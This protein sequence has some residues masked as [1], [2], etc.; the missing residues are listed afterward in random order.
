MHVDSGYKGTRIRE[1]FTEPFIV[2]EQR[3]ARNKKHDTPES[4]DEV[5]R[6]EGIG[7]EGRFH[8][9]LKDAGIY[10][11]EEFLQAY[12]R[13]PKELKSILGRTMTETKWIPLIN[14]AQKCPP[15]EKRLV[16]Y[17][18]DGSNNAVLFD[19]FARLTGFI[20]NDVPQLIHSLSNRE[21]QAADCLVKLAYKNWKEVT[22]YEA[23]IPCHEAVGVPP[24][25]HDLI[26]IDPS[27]SQNHPTQT[28]LR[29]H[30]ETSTF[31]SQGRSSIP[32]ETTNSSMAANEATVSHQQFQAWEPSTD[33]L[34][35]GFAS[36]Q[37][38]CDWL[39]GVT[40]EDLVSYVT[41][42]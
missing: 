19:N 32:D 36:P 38:N 10:N 21:K 20:Q 12:N 5:W 22:K 2:L 3:G 35:A 24:G 13:N 26:P 15:N 8:N 9:R 18:S 23:M 4:S 11:V 39:N 25:T 29:E 7:K 17:S 6:L 33:A 37:G 1:A 41:R 30:H 31:W 34:P 40:M 27:S 16:Y 42:P 14:H 28:S